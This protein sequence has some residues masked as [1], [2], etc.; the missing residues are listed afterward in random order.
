MPESIG[1]KG[2][3]AW[4]I[5]WLIL[6][7]YNSTQASCVNSHTCGAGDLFLFAITEI[8]LLAPGWVVAILVS[9]FFP[10]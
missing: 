7:G 6:T 10:K 5:T 4:A 9:I 2:Y 8:G 3:Y 1:K